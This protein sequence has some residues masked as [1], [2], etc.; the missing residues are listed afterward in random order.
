M[1]NLNENILKTIND[2]GRAFCN[3]SLTMLVQA[4]VLIVLLFIID[5]LIRKRVRATF[6]YW[7][8][9]LVFI[10]L[11]LP[12]A[13]SLPTGIGNWFGEYFV[14]SSTGSAKEPDNITQ[15]EAEPVQSARI[16][17]SEF[18]P[19][20][21]PQLQNDNRPFVSQAAP[22]LENSYQ[23]LTN[24]PIE[25]TKI[26][27]TAVLISN[28][29]TWQ[30]GIFLIWLVGVLVLSAVLIQR[31]FF[32]KE[33]IAQSEPVK[34]RLL[35]TLQDC[36]KQLGI[37]R[38]IQMKL[39]YNASS[40]AVCGLFNPVILIPRGL[41]E[42]I[43]H[44]KFKAIL[45][46]ELSH[47]KRADLWVNCL[48]TMLQIIYFY[49]PLVWL[50][51][52]I[53]RRIREQ[54]VDEM[55]L[56]A[57][58]AEAK[59]YSNT[60]IDVAEMA[61][62]RPTLSLRL[63]GV[64]ESKKALSER[65]KHILSRPIPK[66]AKLGILGLIVIMVVAAILLPMAKRQ[67]DKK[68]L[69]DKNTLIKFNSTSD[70]LGD[71]KTVNDT[72]SFSKT[73]DVKIKK[74]EKL[75]IVA[76]LYRAGEPMKIIGHKLFE[77]TNDSEKLIGNFSYTNLD[78]SKT[79]TK[80]RGNV[81][82]GEQL[83]NIPEFRT[84]FFPSSTWWG[85]FNGNAIHKSTDWRGRDYEAMEILFYYAGTYSDSKNE[86]KFWIPANDTTPV[87]VSY[88]FVLKEIPLSRLEFLYVEPIG[89]YQGLDGKIIEKGKKVK[90]AEMMSNEYKQMLLN[91][92]NNLPND[93]YSATLPNGGTIELVGVCKK[94]QPNQPWYSPD[95]KVQLDKSEE[96]F[97]KRNGDFATINRPNIDTYEFY[98][99][100]D[101]P[102]N[103]TNRVVKNI[104]LFEPDV[105]ITGGLSSSFNHGQHYFQAIMGFPDTMEKVN[106]TF[107]VSNGQWKTIAQ[108]DGSNEKEI[109]IT[110]RGQKQ[111]VT[112]GKIEE[113]DGSLFIEVKHKIK[114]LA[115]GIVAIDKYDKV[116]HP[117]E[118]KHETDGDFIKTVCKFD[119]ISKDRIDH[120]E[121]QIQPS[122]IVTFKD[123]SLKDGYYSNPTITTSSI[124]EETPIT[125][126]S[127][128]NIETNKTFSAT[129]P[130]GVTVELLGICEHPSEGK[131][132]WKP[133]GTLLEQKPYDQLYIT[134]IPEAK[135]NEKVYEYAFRMSKGMDS[136]T[137]SVKGEIIEHG[138]YAIRPEKSGVPADDISSHISYLPKDQEVT[139]ITISSAVFKNIS[140]R[141][142]VKT[143][144]QIEIKEP[145]Q[146]DFKATLA[147]GGTIELVGL[148]KEPIED[149]KWWKP[150]GDEMPEPAFEAST[151]TPSM[152]DIP[153]RYTFLAKAQSG[154]NISMK[155]KIYEGFGNLTKTAQDGSALCFVKYPDE[156]KPNHA[157]AFEK[158]PVEI[159]IAQGQLIKGR[160]AVG[161][162]LNI[163]RE[164][165]IGNNDEIV[166]QQP[167]ADNAE[168][169]TVTN[170]WASVTSHDY[171][172]KLVCK[173]KDGST[174][175]SEQA[176]FQSTN[177]IETG[178]L[179][180]SAINTFPF[181]FDRLTFDQIVDYELY[182][183]KFEFVR[184][185]NVAFKPDIKTKVEIANQRNS[186]AEKADINPNAINATN[187]TAEMAGTW[188]FDNP[189]GDDEQMAIFPDG[190]VVVLYSNGH[191]DQT[192]YDK[193]IIELA[194]YSNNKYKLSLQENGT[195]IQY[196]V[197]QESSL[198]KIWR[199]IDT[200]PKTE[201][202][203]SPKGDENKTETSVVNN[204]S[205]ASKLPSLVGYWSFDG[206]ADDISV[207]KNNGT[208]HGATLTEGIEGQAYSFNGK[209]DYIEMQ[210]DSSYNFG[211]GDFAVE[212][213]IYPKAH[214]HKSIVSRWELGRWAWDFR[215]GW[216]YGEKD[217]LYF[218]FRSDTEHGIKISDTVSLNR[219]HHVVATKRNGI[220]YGYLDG[221]EYN[222]GVQNGIAGDT[223]AN[224]IIG[225][226]KGYGNGY[227][228]GKIDEVKIYNRA[229]TSEEVNLNYKKEIAKDLHMPFEEHQITTSAANKSDK[230]VV[231]SEE[232]V[233]GQN[234]TQII[235]QADVVTIKQPLS[236]INEFLTKEIGIVNP[237]NSELTEAQKQKFKEWASSIPGTN[238]ASSPRTITYDGQSTKMS[239]TTSTG[240]E[241]QEKDV[242]SPDGYKPVNA[243]IKT[244]FEL[245]LVPELRKAENNI[246]L[247]VDIDNSEPVENKNVSG[248]PA[249]SKQN[250]ST[251]V[252]IPLGQYS[253]LS[254][255]GVNDFIKPPFSSP[256]TPSS[257]GTS[258][259]NT[260]LVVKAD[261]QESA[262]NKL[263]SLEFRVAPDSVVSSRNPSPLKPE[264]ELKYKEDLK[265]NGPDAGRARNDEYIWIPIRES[266][267]VSFLISEN[268]KDN[269][270]LL[271]C[272]K[273]PF[274]LLSDEVWEIENINTISDS[275]G[276]PAISVEVDEKGGELFYKLTSGNL[277]RSLAIIIGDKV[278]SVPVIRSPLR[279]KL[280]ITGSFTKEDLQKMFKTPPPSP[281]L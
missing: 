25:D 238:I 254:L 56:V 146:S 162:P 24:L 206:N 235:L 93:I 6:R 11:I 109:T 124:T 160:G 88:A 104:W 269:K 52:A 95:G 222:A 208:V 166:I 108:S 181:V 259:S 72:K 122:D 121:F 182:Y 176:Y 212:T 90:E 205:S 3:F 19:R 262:N 152:G 177:I 186:T 237:V 77:Q 101:L 100:C 135:S 78:Q 280:M 22:E 40:P 260:F 26:N 223:E 250:I 13:L 118:N 64:V 33:L 125:Q 103:T 159:G 10:K 31:V 12:P 111:N 154:E 157:D 36:S 251:M 178:V 63:V 168:P 105:D 60:L 188:F 173:L 153:T 83:F 79:A 106:L 115:A 1:N 211:T 14:I 49:N 73:Y 99:H 9:M 96:I 227:F 16:A 53:V 243:T 184:F 215:L 42:K 130:S 69:F 68:D 138:G 86:A 276:L 257:P 230:L 143:N 48:Q 273:K 110:H 216:D 158:G 59:S 190:K 225:M 209:D 272:N 172:F 107:E 43:S 155:A 23:P 80:Y 58:G 156:A 30:G 256:P 150:N 195:L 92:V 75:L 247:K 239:I 41:L 277:N 74:G 245:E 119:G 70:N 50:V 84:D 38:N 136:I 140:L 15:Q 253:M 28:P 218:F 39:S 57:L 144:V 161:E 233:S 167:R 29:L 98:I 198:A 240:Y 21:I 163:P 234:K 207:N 171:E 281:E 113:K 76:E 197:S 133:D 202:I 37:R 149:A 45:I 236:V 226:F 165:L 123:V 132:W 255:G 249:M 120:Y 224:L 200:Q 246:H 185:N 278:T 175:E 174:R 261:L 193:G 17:N 61:F 241:L 213:W 47:I 187:I 20:P 81:K 164:Y 2:I 54:A 55:V 129:L 18:S 204:E 8:W 85:W 169:N 67:S 117:I 267:E 219:W 142:N 5:I 270:Y 66:S 97:S 203:K 65:I 274:V 232:Y 248:P 228:N 217:K 27:E 231:T 199:R 148:C 32:V 82:L 214:D 94:S 89:G 62:S 252:V 271:V 46:H 112:L 229:L 116:W 258:G 194:E 51:N 189:M 266:T 137:I 244:G 264:E 279:N 71:V 4:S 265:Q 221:V 87:E 201:L 263:I 102:S 114:E 268:Y 131:Q 220:L 44:D 145:V 34:N 192:N 275:R 141:P 242:N 128:E 147:N 179:H 134:P 180:N 210:Y 35:E 183:R 151:R 126:T 139:A 91:I 170:I 127:S 196:P 7:I 191:K